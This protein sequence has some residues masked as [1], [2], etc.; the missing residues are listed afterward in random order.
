MT[1]A[2]PSE[3]ITRSKSPLVVEFPFADCGEG[4]TPS[5]RFFIRHHFPV[6]DV[7]PQSWS[8][9]IEGAVDAPRVVSL[10]ALRALPAV[11]VSAVIECAGNGRAFM[12]GFASSVQWELGGVGCATWTG[13][14]L[15]S[16]LADAR[17]HASA[18]DVVFEGAD[19]GPEH[20]LPAGADIH[21]ARSIPLATAMRPDVILA[22]EMNGQPLEMHHGAPLRAIV[23]G[24]YGV[25]SVKWLSRIIVSERPFSGFFQS[26][27]YTYW[28][29][30]T[31]GIERIP[32][33]TLQVK[34][35]I[36]RPYPGEE[37]S[38]GIP[39]RVCGAAWT[40]NASI[41]AVDV[42][43][44]GGTSW[45]AATLA[46]APDEHAWQ[47][48]ELEWIPDTTGT[49]TLMAR[50]TDSGGRV[51]PMTHDVNHENYMVHHALPIAVHVS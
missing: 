18:V 10:D 34:S 46:A 45:H 50:A 9:R 6:P 48:W 29:R 43:T 44:D 14:P 11:T 42:S 37:V 51:Q 39:Y 15:R 30:D 13:V 35:E 2:D 40:S 41:T 21:F 31:S 16:L 5:D 25:T 36:A 22:Y 8:V 19:H 20:K 1:I 47:P 27:E 7:D 24:W 28:K 32:V 17:V 3:P 26:A 4:M 49:C 23:P 12:N 38:I 33:T